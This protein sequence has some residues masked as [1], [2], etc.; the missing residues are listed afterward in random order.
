[1][2][3]RESIVG[4]NNVPGEP[5]LNAKVAG[6]EAGPSTGLHDVLDHVGHVVLVL[7]LLVKLQTDLGH[8]QRLDREPL[9]QRSDSC[10]NCT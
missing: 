3:P 4:S 9:W 6:E 8:L 10:C 5:V 1:M 2:T 7:V